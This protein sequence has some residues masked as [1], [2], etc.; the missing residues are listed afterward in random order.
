VLA[1]LVE[2][3]CYKPEGRGLDFR[4]CHSS[5]DRTMTLELTQS[6]TEMSTKNIS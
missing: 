2:A 1:Q 4:W 5:S 6:L 3:L